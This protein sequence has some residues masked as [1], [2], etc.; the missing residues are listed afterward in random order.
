[1][2]SQ[3]GAITFSQS[4]WSNALQCQGSPEHRAEPTEAH[5]QNIYLAGYTHQSSN[6]T[7]HSPHGD[8]PSH[9]CCEES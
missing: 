1:M 6:Q 3:P 8:I 5:W 7:S 2:D 4:H 9:Q